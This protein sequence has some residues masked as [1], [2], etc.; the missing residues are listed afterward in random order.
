MFKVSV[1]I[2]VYNTEK[3]LVDCLESVVNQTLQDLE[4]VLINDGS[5]DDSLKIMEMYQAK[6]AD[7]IQLI[8]RENGGQAVARNM[9]IPLCRGEYI[10][11]VDSD[12]YI[13]PEMYERMYVK[14]KE[15]DA[16]Y[17]ECDY[18]NVK[19]N[20]NGEQERIA[21]YGS[22][23]RAYTSKKDMF[24]DP[25]LAPW[26]KL[27]R[28]ELLKKSNV[29]FPE[30]LI[31]ED[32]SFC[33]KSISFINNFAFVPEKYVVHFYRGS[34]T[35]NGNKS[36]KVADIFKVLEDVI[37][38]YQDKN[39]FYEYQDELEYEIVKILLCSSMERIS[40]VPDSKLKKQLCRDTWAFIQKYFPGYK[41]NKYIREKGMKNRYMSLITGWNIS[42]VCKVLSRKKGVA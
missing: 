10:G 25:M 15:T 22:R 34:S 32:T 5:T 35:M 4:V 13:E 33:L 12:D 40:Q 37:T 2:P 11:F 8:S 1:I 19:L 21:D 18:V 38:F 7:R 36:Q 39:L 29:F 3:Y 24:I 9:A 27:Y 6:Y 30:G 20:E 26:N 31:Y 42:T 23:V 28:T 14:A 41:K 17:V 16:D